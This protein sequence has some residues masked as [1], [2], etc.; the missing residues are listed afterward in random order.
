MSTNGTIPKSIATHLPGALHKK[1][2]RPGLSMSVCFTHGHE[3]LD[4]S[5]GDR[6]GAAQVICHGD[7]SF[8]QG[9]ASQGRGDAARR[10]Y[11]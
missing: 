1:A 8:G 6:I 4:V 10:E 2:A 11:S 3:T 7:R 5:A 9:R